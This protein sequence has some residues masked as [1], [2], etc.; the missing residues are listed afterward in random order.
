MHWMYSGGL[1][2]REMIEQLAEG[3]QEALRGLME[4]CLSPE[5][6]GYTPSDFPLAQASELDA[7]EL[8][9]IAEWESKIVSGAD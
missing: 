2:G 7:E 5:A 6:G 8:D 4:H 9:R 1:H 3:Y